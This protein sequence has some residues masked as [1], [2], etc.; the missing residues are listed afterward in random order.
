MKPAIELVKEW[1]SYG[2]D[3]D[4]CADELEA[5]LRDAD[6]YL[7]VEQKLCEKVEMQLSDGGKYNNRHYGGRAFSCGR[8][9]EVL[10]G[11]TQKPKQEREKR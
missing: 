8:F 3:Y 1:R 10:L 7:R 4:A 6:E 2:K 9:R 11:T 5:W